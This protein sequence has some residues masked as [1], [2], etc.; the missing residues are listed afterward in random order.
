MSQSR[1]LRARTVV[2]HFM[3]HPNSGV[4]LQMGNTVDE[5]IRRSNVKL[6]FNK[7]FDSNLTQN[8]VSNIKYMLTHV[9]QFTETEFDWL[10]IHGYEVADITFQCYTPDVYS[11]I[12]YKQIAT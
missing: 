1:G 3:S 2:N 12:P 11:H 4:Y 6:D 5:I 7:H 8:Q 10:F 9:K